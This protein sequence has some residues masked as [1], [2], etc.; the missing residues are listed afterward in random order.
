MNKY[1]GIIQNL[2]EL[3]EEYKYNSKF[4]EETTKDII[5]DYKN[6]LPDGFNKSGLYLKGFIENKEEMVNKRELENE[7]L[8]GE[9]LSLKVKI[10]NMLKYFSKDLKQLEKGRVL[11]LLE[12]TYCSPFE[13]EGLKGYGLELYKIINFAIEN[14]LN[15]YL[16]FK[17]LT[18]HC[19]KVFDSDLKEWV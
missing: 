10:D 8:T 3:E 14:K 18:K 11:K 1:K 17:T 15:F 7:K 16:Q 12:K 2:K 6:M 4:I 9:I 19:L 13:K 5:Q